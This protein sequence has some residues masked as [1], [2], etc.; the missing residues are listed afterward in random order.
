MAGLPEAE[1][2]WGILGEGSWEGLTW[3]LAGWYWLLAG[4][5]SCHVDFL[6][7]LFVS[8]HAMAADIPW[9]ECP[10]SH[11]VF[12]DPETEST[13]HHFCNILL[14]LQASLIQQGRQLYKSMNTSRSEALEVILEA[15][16][17]ESYVN[18]NLF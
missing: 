14:I 8:P 5:T 18:F 2:F 3:M 15:D 12:Y 11:N 16:Y 10:R 9:N 7:G 13:C 6:T 17:Q 4:V 1:E